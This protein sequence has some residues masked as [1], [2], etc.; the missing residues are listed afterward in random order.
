MAPTWKRALASLLMTLG[1]GFVVASP[2][3]ADATLAGKV[4]DHIGAGMCLKLPVSGFQ[5]GM[6]ISVAEPA[7]SPGNWTETQVGSVSA[8]WPFNDQQ[9]WNNQFMNDPVLKF[10]S[11]RYPGYCATDAGSGGYPLRNVTAESC[12]ALR[13]QYYVEDAHR[14]I[15]VAATDNVN[16]VEELSTLFYQR[17]GFAVDAPPGYDPGFAPPFTYGQQHWC[18]VV[19]G[20]CTGP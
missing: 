18:L 3:L 14:L 6:G 19:N 4:C 5:P 15:N 2:G 8:S 9:P 10:E 12:G 7:Q 17:Q 20:T 13:T 1:T 11:V 16:T